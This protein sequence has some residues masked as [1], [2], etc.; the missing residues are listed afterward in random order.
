M[1]DVD[2]KSNVVI[3]YTTKINHMTTDALIYNAVMA[4]TNMRM[5]G[6][7]QLT[8]KWEQKNSRNDLWEM[9]PD[10]R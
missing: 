6:S 1:A 10:K 3:D 8:K 5:I 4:H 7:V 2:S 9:F